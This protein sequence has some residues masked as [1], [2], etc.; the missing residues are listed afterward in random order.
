MNNKLLRNVLNML[1]YIL[2]IVVIAIILFII[3]LVIG[4]GVLGGEEIGDIFKGQFWSTV[5]AFFQ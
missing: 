1:L 5:T 2:L 4:Y 3:G